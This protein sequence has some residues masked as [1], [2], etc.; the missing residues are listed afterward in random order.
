[1][2]KLKLGFKAESGNWKLTPLHAHIDRM[3]VKQLKG[4]EIFAHLIIQREG[5]Q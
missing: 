2:P 4:R 5:Y 1:M 3:T